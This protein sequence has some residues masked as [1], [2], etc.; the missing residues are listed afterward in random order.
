MP[1][2]F[3][4]DD[5][6][7][8]ITDK[9]VRLI[10]PLMLEELEQ[11]ALSNFENRLHEGYLLTLNSAKNSG[12]RSVIFVMHKNRSEHKLYEEAYGILINAAQDF[13]VDSEL[14]IFFLFED[15]D[16]TDTASLKTF[17]EITDFINDEFD[18]RPVQASRLQ[19]V[20]KEL[21]DTAPAFGDKKT[22]FADTL[23]QFMLKKNLESTDVW[24]K[25]NIDRKLFSKIFNGGQPS[26]K[27][28][29]LITLALELNLDDSLDLLARAGYTLSD[30][31]K[32][33]IAVKWHILNNRHSV[34]DVGETLLRHGLTSLF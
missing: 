27:T 31:I 14:N 5:K 30:A 22:S 1:I 15:E 25:A 29:I 9:Y 8:I 19:F 28:A 17:N 3:V 21:R 26:K 20:D 18:K 4:L 32:T 11:F 13:L 34:Y 7:T 24:K 23:N 12:A 6:K 2:E 10:K 33:D 16:K